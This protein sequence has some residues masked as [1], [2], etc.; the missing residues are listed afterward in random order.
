M[1]YKLLIKSEPLLELSQNRRQKK[2]S[3]SS[4]RK[5]KAAVKGPKTVKKVVSKASIGAVRKGEKVKLAAEKEEEAEVEEAK[6]EEAKVEEVK[7]EGVVIPIGSPLF[8]LMLVLETHVFMD[9]LA[10]GWDVGNGQE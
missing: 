5:T 8:G 4:T 7:A 1:D 9:A 3:S 2:S 10:P 6:V